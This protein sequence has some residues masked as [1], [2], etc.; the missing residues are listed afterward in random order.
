MTQND[1]RKGDIL[2]PGFGTN[3]KDL[4]IDICIA[5]ACCKTYTPLSCDTQCHAMLILEGR[6][7]DKYLMA[8]KNV[9]AEFKPSFGNGNAW[10]YIRH[11]QK[12][13][14]ETSYRSE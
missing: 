5:N 12:V 13:F 2:F 7:N 4:V 3:G 14:Q 10:P 8:Y 6:K 11:L 9:G 1:N